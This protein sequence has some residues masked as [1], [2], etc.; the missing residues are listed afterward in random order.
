MHRFRQQ[1]VRLPHFAK[2]RVVTLKTRK[3]L[4]KAC[5]ALLVIEKR[6]FSASPATPYSS[7]RSLNNLRADV[8]KP[9]AYGN[10]PIAPT[11]RRC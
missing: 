9:R 5:V 4:V 11:L 6:S 8:G 10:A 3:I 1:A 7:R 2:L